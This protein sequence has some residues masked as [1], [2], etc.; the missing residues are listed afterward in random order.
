VIRPVSLETNDHSHSHLK[1]HMA[2]TFRVSWPGQNGP[3]IA[4][5]CE[6]MLSHC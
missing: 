5:A 6:H 2:V 4:F 1:R 3:L